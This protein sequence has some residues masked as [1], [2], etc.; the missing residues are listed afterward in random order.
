[1]T[2]IKYTHLAFSSNV[3]HLSVSYTIL[4]HGY[5]NVNQQLVNIGTPF[6]MRSICVQLT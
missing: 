3:M 6:K 4:Y 2:T 1:M 5:E